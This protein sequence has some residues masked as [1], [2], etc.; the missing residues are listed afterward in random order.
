MVPGDRLTVRKAS[1]ARIPPALPAFGREQKQRCQMSIFCFGL[2]HQ[3]AAIDVGERFAIPES[4]LP[5]ALAELQEGMRRTNSEQKRRLAIC[6]RQDKF[7]RASMVEWLLSR[8]ERLIVAW[9]EVP[10]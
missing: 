10:G 9:Y 3:T 1:E 7:W 5:E 8:R 2:N 4:A 6:E